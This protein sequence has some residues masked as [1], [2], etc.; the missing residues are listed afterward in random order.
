M[1]SESFLEFTEVLLK[2]KGD[3]YHRQVSRHFSL[4][5]FDGNLSDEAAIV[6]HSERPFK[7]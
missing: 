4:K 7:T 3:I 5:S 1:R 6:A 2:L